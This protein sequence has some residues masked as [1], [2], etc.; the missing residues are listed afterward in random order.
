MGQTDTLY[1]G[2]FTKVIARQ[3]HIGSAFYPSCGYDIV[4]SL[5]IPEIVYLDH[6]MAVADFFSNREK[7]LNDLSGRKA[8]SEPC[9]FFL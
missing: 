6:F 5:Y 2:R 3:Y 7:L 8:Y 1:A 4:L 9:R